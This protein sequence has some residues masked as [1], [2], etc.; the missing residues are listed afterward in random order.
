MRFISPSLKSFETK[1]VEETRPSQG[2]FPKS[3]CPPKPRRI[4]SG[5]V[6][7]LFPEAPAR[8]T[9]PCRSEVLLRRVEVEAA[10]P[11]SRQERTMSLDSVKGFLN[12]SAGQTS[13]LLALGSGIA[14]AGGA[15]VQVAETGAP[16]NKWSATTADFSS[17]GDWVVIEV[18]RGFSLF[19]K[20]SRR[21]KFLTEN[22]NITVTI[23]PL[24]SGGGSGT[25]V[26]LTTTI[27]GII[28]SHL[29]LSVLVI[30]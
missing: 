23:T 9:A 12:D 14:G 28:D 4:Q 5:V 24:D 29:I 20:R 6:W 11:S 17:A 19:K 15:T 21:R 8:T 22:L 18:R 10:A 3:A 26:S 7:Y 25:A 1:A 16:A 30:P 13:L 27:T 2:I